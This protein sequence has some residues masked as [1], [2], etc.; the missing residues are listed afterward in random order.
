LP[1]NTIRVLV[2]SR[3]YGSQLAPL[4]NLLP[5]LHRFETNFDESINWSLK[6]DTSHLSLADLRVTLK[7]PL[8][9]LDEM[10]L[11]MP[12][13]KR[14]RVKGKINEDSVFEYFEKFI[15]ILHF[16]VPILQRYDC[17]LYYRSW[18]DQVDVIVIQQLNPLF[19][20]IQCFL[21]NII[22]RCYT[23]DLT[24]YPSISD[25]TCKYRLVDLLLLEVK[26]YIF[27]IMSSKNN[28]MHCR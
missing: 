11:H 2:L 15:Q 6:S 23:T 28:F 3:W 7:D 19:N 24:E 4:F 20:K 18:N 21:E 8:N 9:D 5:N 25:Y 17:E 16:H 26:I 12:N 27:K 14:L 1:N 10:L 13:L 22:N